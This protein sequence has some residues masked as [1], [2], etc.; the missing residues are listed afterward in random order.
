M[1][2]E[3]DESPEAY[4]CTL[5]VDHEGSRVWISH[6]VR[7]QF[8]RLEE[9]CQEKL[10]SYM[11]LWCEE[12]ALTKEMFNGNEG[13]SPGGIMLK[14]FKRYQARMYGFERDID[15]VRTFVIVDC[16]PAKKRTP[17]KQADLKRA[18]KR[19]D[20]FGKEKK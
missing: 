1:R 2:D 6:K 17:A 14:A 3:N 4:G 7:R 19:A 13:R 11:E 5:L 15:N 9:A 16:N 8:D 12:R 18:R 10:K 20:S